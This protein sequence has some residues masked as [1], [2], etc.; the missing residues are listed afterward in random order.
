VDPVEGA[1]S[2]KPTNSALPEEFAP[3]S[4]KYQNI[5]TKNKLFRFGTSVDDY[6]FE[7]TANTL[8]GAKIKLVAT[9]IDGGTDF[10]VET[11][12]E[13]NEVSGNKV[14]L[15]VAPTD[16]MPYQNYLSTHKFEITISQPDK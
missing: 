8:K 12:L 5:G 7:V 3:F 15:L 2:A 14:I 1:E 16:T 10:T 11:V 13:G 4:P 9:A 6:P